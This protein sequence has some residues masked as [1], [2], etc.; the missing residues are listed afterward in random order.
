MS[1]KTV[2]LL[3]LCSINCKLIAAHW[4]NNNTYSIETTIDQSV[5]ESRVVDRYDEKVLVNDET[6]E[7]S[8]AN[9][10]FSSYSLYPGYKVQAIYSIL[11]A[12]FSFLCKI[13]G[14]MRRFHVLKRCVNHIAGIFIKIYRYL[15]I[16]CPDLLVLLTR[17]KRCTSDTLYE[18]IKDNI[19]WQ[20][21]MT[22]WTY[23]GDTDCKNI[24]S[25]R[26]ILNFIEKVI[27]IRELQHKLAVCVRVSNGDRWSA[28]IRMQ[29]DDCRVYETAWDVPCSLKGNIEYTYDNYSS[30][31]SKMSN[32]ILM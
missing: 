15:G 5:A 26:D 18:L 24:T 25:E 11:K 16:Q 29:R 13:F 22:I 4:V 32:E 12:P 7:T 19:S 20:L 21:T 14:V 2:F 9:R 10:T 17:N 6:Y 1:I 31:M 28:D 30:N 23:E 27:D 3:I 8:L